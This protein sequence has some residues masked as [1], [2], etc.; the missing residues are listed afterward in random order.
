MNI[1]KSEWVLKKNYFKV[2][3]ID[4][5]KL[6]YIEW[7]TEQGHDHDDLDML[8]F[9]EEVTSRD[10]VELYQFP[11][12]FPFKTNDVEF[13]YFEKVDDNHVLPRMLFTLI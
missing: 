8:K 3:L 7:M 2:K 5:F 9:I 6:E 11:H 12:D 13:D 10:D 4:N 1:V